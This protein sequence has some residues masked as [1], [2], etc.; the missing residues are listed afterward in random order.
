M[1]LVVVGSNLGVTWGVM[2][3]GSKTVDKGL[4]ETQREKD[5]LSVIDVRRHLYW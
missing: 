5:H 2:N 1:T 4:S 3:Q